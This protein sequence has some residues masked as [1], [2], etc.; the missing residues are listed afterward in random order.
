MEDIYS[1]SSEEL[2]VEDGDLSDA[3]L[4]DGDDEVDDKILEE[5]GDENY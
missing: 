1:D 4:N 2:D 5:E 3:D